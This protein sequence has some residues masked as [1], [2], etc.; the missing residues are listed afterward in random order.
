MNAPRLKNL[1][2]HAIAMHRA[3]PTSILGALSMSEKSYVR[4]PAALRIA[5]I[6]NDFW[7]LTRCGAQNA[8]VALILEKKSNNQTH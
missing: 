6:W 2:K 7:I 4:C 5:L 3:Y 1:R 8:W